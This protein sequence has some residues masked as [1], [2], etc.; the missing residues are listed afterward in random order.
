MKYIN[1]M[2]ASGDDEKH[3]ALMA[4]VGLRGYGAYWIIA[5]KI[6]A[7]IRPE[8]CDTSM[9]LTWQRWGNH[10]GVEGDSARRLI[11]SM[12]EV[13]LIELEE[14]GKIACVNMPNILKYADEYTKRVGIKSGHS[15]DTTRDKLR[16]LSG[17]PALPA[18]PEE[19]DLKNRPC[20]IVDN[21]ASGDGA[22][23]GVALLGAAPPPA[24]PPEDPDPEILKAQEDLLRR[25]REL[26]IPE[27][28]RADPT[29]AMK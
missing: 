1:H 14:A 28:G 2:T 17:T 29:Q 21:S 8:S 11:R 7:Q 15:P 22:D 10:L 12:A 18:V 24:P 5:E 3:Q 26:G 19:Q 4:R 20:G 25:R 16:K 23:G 9:G 27:I 6:G 13:G